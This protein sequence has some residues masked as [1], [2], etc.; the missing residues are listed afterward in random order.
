MASAAQEPTPRGRRAT[1]AAGADRAAWWWRFRRRRRVPDESD[2][3][4]RVGE[5][6]ESSHRSLRPF[7]TNAA[8]AAA[9][10]ASAHCAHGIHWLQLQCAGLRRTASRC[11]RIASLGSYM[12]IVHVCAAFNSSAIASVLQAAS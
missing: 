1:I 2:I 11:Y 5:L 9:A 7:V 6:A 4:Q 3:V 10:S 12:L 8:A